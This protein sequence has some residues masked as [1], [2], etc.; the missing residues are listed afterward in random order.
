MADDVGR[1]APVELEEPELPLAAGNAGGDHCAEEGAAA[2]V[3]E[4]PPPPSAETGGIGDSGKAPEACDV[5][6]TR[7]DSEQ[8]QEGQPY[9]PAAF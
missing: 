1:G 6:P 3:E 8:Q 9:P 4:P 7:D 2:G 5:E